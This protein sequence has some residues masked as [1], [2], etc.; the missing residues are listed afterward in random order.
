[1]KMNLNLNFTL[2]LR[3]YNDAV[4]LKLKNIM[5]E[6]YHFIPT[7]MTK[8]SSRRKMEMEIDRDG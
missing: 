2:F 6:E 7:R 8:G 4:A 3:L 5:L 1:M